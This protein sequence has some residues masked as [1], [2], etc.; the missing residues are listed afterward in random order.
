M[1]FQFYCP[2]GHLLQADDA[3]AGS[4]IACPVCS[5]QFIIPPPPPQAV[6][7]AAPVVTPVVEQC[8]EQGVVPTES[9][10]S[11][12][13][14]SAAAQNRSASGGNA[15]KSFA[16][17]KLRGTDENSMNAPDD[18][19]PFDMMKQKKEKAQKMHDAARTKEMLAQA[20]KAPPKAEDLDLLHIPCPKGH[21]LDVDKEML[22]QR[23]QCPVCRSVYDLMLENS[24][25]FIQEK[26]KERE[27]EEIRLG[28]VWIVWAI[29]GLIL[30]LLFLLFLLFT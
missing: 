21:V 22:G 10:L 28:K 24:L 20:V 1:N 2:K 15:F 9:P 13:D 25:E 11:N 7:V 27:L 23:V 4:V 12:L 19:N 17:D 14:F 18:A 3:H 8:V 6:P 16:D 5:M 29:V 26:K 30:L